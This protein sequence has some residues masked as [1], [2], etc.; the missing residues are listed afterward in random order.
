[1]PYSNILDRVDAQ[2][3][4]P[5]DTS[6]EILQHVAEDSIV[7]SLAR[8]APD[9]TAKQRE[10]PVLA[11]L[12]TA[13][14]VN[15]DTGLKQTTEVSWDKV[16]LVAEELAV[17]VP[18]PEAVIADAQYDI[19]GQMRPL[20]QEAFGIAF[21]QAVLHS[22]NKPASWP[23]AIVPTAI[24]RGNSVAAGTGADLYTDVMGVGGVIAKVEEDGFMV[25]GHVASLSLRAML[26]GL[27]SGG[28]TGTPL[29]ETNLQ[30]SRRY[31]LD[32]EPLVFPRNGA[33]DPAQ[34]LMISGDWTQLIYA[35]RQDLTFRVITEG[36]IQDN[37]GA[38]VLNLAQQDAVA[39]RCVM[40]IAYA[41][42]VILE[43]IGGTAAQRF[44][45]SVLT[46]DLTP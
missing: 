6:N 14:F 2:A 42:P 31:A 37:T 19:F 1:M 44:P 15:G 3:L 13:Y 32:G 43:R 46:P 25:N 34:S 41:L 10:T 20:I 40:R 5:V 33:L 27:R 24:A 23:G 12:P 26:R 8:R 22:I 21:D 35:I 39:L 36:V 11:S 18:V 38:I 29:L 17:I 7:M 28:A 30:D 9:M 4:I 45:F 16:T